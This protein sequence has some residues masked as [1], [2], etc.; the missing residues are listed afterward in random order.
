MKSLLIVISFLSLFGFVS[1]QQPPTPQQPQQPQP[2]QP[3]VQN[4]QSVPTEAE[5]RA[6]INREYGQKLAALNTINGNNRIDQR[7]RAAYEKM[8]ELYRKPNKDELKL[9][10]PNQTDLKKFAEFLNQPNTGI[11]K[12]TRDLGCADNPDVVNASADCLLYTM[13]G[14]GSSFSFRTNN[15]RIRRLADLTFTDNRFLATGFLLH[16]I[17]VDLG[18][19]PLEQISLSAKGLQFIND[20][21]AVNSFQK[22]KD[23]DRDLINGIEKN[24]FVYR[25]AVQAKENSTYILRSIAYRGNSY[26]AAQGF[27]YDE[28]NFDK[29]RDI[30]VAFRIVSRDEDGSVTIIWKELQDKK[31]PKIEK[32][33]ETPTGGIKEDN[34]MAEKVFR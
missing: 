26:R 18:D 24:G 30:I 12:L 20:F 8:E 17:F 33:K 32:Y 29:R 1:G 5:R 16:G 10:A 13:P 25:R 11:I 23:I 22:A 6:A 7:S 27:S 4:V 19:V 15:Y 34:F 21:Q 2:P 14:G 9:L 28:F 3:P 31:S